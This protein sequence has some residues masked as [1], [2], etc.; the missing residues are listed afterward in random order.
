[1]NFHAL[2]TI[3]EALLTHILKYTAKINL[4]ITPL[5]TMANEKYPRYFQL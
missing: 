2:T 5:H 4:F 3:N 1:M